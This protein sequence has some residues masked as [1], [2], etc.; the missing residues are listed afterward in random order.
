MQRRRNYEFEKVL[1][2]LGRSLKPKIYCYF[3]N[4][5]VNC[6]TFTAFYFADK[7]SNQQQ[8]CWLRLQGRS[9]LALSL[10][11]DNQEKN[12]RTH[13]QNLIIVTKDFQTAHGEL[14]NVEVRPKSCCFYKYLAVNYFTFLLFILRT[15]FLM[16]SKSWGIKRLPNGGDGR[17]DMTQRISTGS[18]RPFIERIVAKYRFLLSI[19]LLTVV[20]ITSKRE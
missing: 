13:C 5:I 19:L 7:F 4:L 17:P 8:I 1:L 15:N 14:F 16:S 6:F 9:H 18:S 12:H 3:E 2:L 11:F 20:P 10:V